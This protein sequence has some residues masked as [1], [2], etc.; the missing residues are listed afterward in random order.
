MCL[1]YFILAFLLLFLFYLHEE[2]KI[3]NIPNTKIKNLDLI[4]FSLFVF[5]RH[6]FLT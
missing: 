5:L 1:F 4:L 3:K 6:I 2:T